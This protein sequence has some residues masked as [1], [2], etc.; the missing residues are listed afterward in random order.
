MLYGTANPLGILSLRADRNGTFAVVCM[1][2]GRVVPGRRRICGVTPY[3][4]HHCT[5]CIRGGEDAGTLL[6]CGR[7]IGEYLIIC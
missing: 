7:C 5:L 1:V 2:G 3:C 6:V 4:I